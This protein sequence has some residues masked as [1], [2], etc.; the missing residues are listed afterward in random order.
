[1]ITYITVMTC[2]LFVFVCGC[3]LFRPVPPPKKREPLCKQLAD[4]LATR[5]RVSYGSDL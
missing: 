4:Q 5:N 1:M 2:L 3:A